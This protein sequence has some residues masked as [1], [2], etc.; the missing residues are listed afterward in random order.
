MSPEEQRTLALNQANRVRIG[1]AHL[2][3]RVLTGEMTLRE[4]LDDPIVSEARLA[5][6]VARAIYT[7]GARS[8]GEV[9]ACDVLTLMGTRASITVGHLSESRKDEFCE[10]LRGRSCGAFAYRRKAAA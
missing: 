1:R 10:R 2:A 5:Q 8:R 3:D 9:A 7:R 4:A 6:F